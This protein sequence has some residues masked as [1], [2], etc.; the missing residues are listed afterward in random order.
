M[1]LLLKSVFLVTAI[2]YPM[3]SLTQQIQYSTR[4]FKVPSSYDERI[5]AGYPGHSLKSV[6]DAKV[7]KMKSFKNQ[8]EYE[9][10]EKFLARFS[11]YQNRPILGQLNEDS[12]VA[13]VMPK[14][15]TK[16]DIDLQMLF[17]VI[18]C[19]NYA[20][21]DSDLDFENV[22]LTVTS[23]VS[24]TKK[25]GKTRM[26]ISFHYTEHAGTDYSILLPK[27]ETIDPSQNIVL[28]IKMTP[29]KSKLVRSNLK[30]LFVGKLD[31]ISAGLEGH[32]A[33]LDEPYEDAILHK[34][35][36]LKEVQFLVF[37]G[38]SGELYKP[39]IEPF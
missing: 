26:G 19:V 24:S 3:V 39:D 25:T 27:T 12:T 23:N 13:F 4:P 17:V 22:A 32:A 29:E 14:V 5:P 1:K 7:S 2:T 30:V 15:T 33:R 21:K 6:Y 20:Y 8:G 9:T 11:A 36:L 38:K 31:K 16:Y 18:G 35:L 10:R 28:G 34:Y 37:N